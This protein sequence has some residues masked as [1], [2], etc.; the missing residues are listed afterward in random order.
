MLVKGH[1]GE[2]VGVA[3]DEKG[4]TLGPT[5]PGQYGPRQMSLKT[6][7]EGPNVEPFAQERRLRLTLALT[8]SSPCFHENVWKIA[9]ERED[10]GLWSDMTKQAQAGA[11]HWPSNLHVPMQHWRLIPSW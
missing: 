5:C 7:S 6:K 4:M 8:P 11:R 9:R 2:N 1:G 10:P 3:G